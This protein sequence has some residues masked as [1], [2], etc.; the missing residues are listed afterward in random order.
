MYHICFFGCLSFWEAAVINIGPKGSY[1]QDL[2]NSL[3][4]PSTA[5]DLGW[6]EA[7]CLPRSGR[8]GLLHSLIL[9]QSR[10]K[11]NSSPGWSFNHSVQNSNSTGEDSQSVARG[12]QNSHI[13]SPTKCI[14]LGKCNSPKRNQARINDRQPKTWR[15]KV[16]AISNTAEGETSS[17]RGNT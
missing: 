16:P 3:C 12:G 15:Q 17:K 8:Q 13:N 10:K 2:G 6:S 14:Q 9:T 1:W 5:R 11:M 7:E 4:H